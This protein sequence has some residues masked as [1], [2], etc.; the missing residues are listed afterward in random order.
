MV[1]TTPWAVHEA[2][3][4]T[5]KTWDTEKSVKTPKNVDMKLSAYDVFLE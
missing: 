3:K 2:N 4:M 5:I 1:T